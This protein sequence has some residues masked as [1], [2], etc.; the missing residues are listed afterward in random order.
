MPDKSKD[1][2]DECFDIY[3][4]E[5]GIGMKER[6]LIIDY[7]AKRVDEACKEQRERDTR[8]INR[9]PSINGIKGL[10]GKKEAI[11]AIRNAPEPK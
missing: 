8:I 9:Q 11:E 6:R 5:M 7:A 2:A 3:L 1:S 10:I 4:T